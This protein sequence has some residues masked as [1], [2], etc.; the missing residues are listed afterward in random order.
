[1]PWEA[2][3][4]S[5]LAGLGPMPLKRVSPSLPSAVTPGSL[6]LSPESSALGLVGAW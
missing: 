5:T 4:S 6:Q 2:R 3:C 1:M